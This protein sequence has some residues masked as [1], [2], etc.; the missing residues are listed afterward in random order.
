MKIDSET[1][2]YRGH[3]I[4]IDIH[5]DEHMGPPWE[6]HD[7]HGIVSDWEHRDKRPGEW[8]LY[9]DGRSKRFYDVTETLKRAKADGWGLGEE[10]N[11]KLTKRL[12]HKPT[13]KEVIAESVRQD[14]E[15]LRRWCN[16]DWVWLG[17]TTEIE[18]PEGNTVSGD[19]CWGFD[20]REY[21]LS[22][23]K[24]QAEFTIDKLIKDK[25]AE[26]KESLAMA[27]RDIATV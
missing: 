10:E 20:D 19:S 15:Y 11:A 27:C 2:E 22:E 5:H 14:F 7:G 3:A 16:D 25:E 18:T 17:Y 6:E 21:M 4:R 26:A 24:G 8:I 23:A 1:Y 12:G 13:N 9:S